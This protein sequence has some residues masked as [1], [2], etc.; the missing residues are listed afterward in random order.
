MKNLGKNITLQTTKEKN[1]NHKL[2]FTQRLYRI[3]G[4]DITLQ[5]TKE[6]ECLQENKCIHIT[7]TYINISIYK[8]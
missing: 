7:T 6:K 4:K 1:V 3:L 8:I 5:I 2:L